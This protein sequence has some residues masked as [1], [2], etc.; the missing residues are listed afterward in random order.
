MLI[1]IEAI[2]IPFRRRYYDKGISDVKAGWD[3]ESHSWFISTRYYV[4]CSKDVSISARE[5]ML[6]EDDI[7]RVCKNVSVLDIK[8]TTISMFCLVTRDVVQKRKTD[9]FVLSIKLK[10]LHQLRKRKIG[11]LTTKSFPSKLYCCES[12]MYQ[13]ENFT[14]WR[15]D[16][17]EQET[18][19]DL[20]YSVFEKNSTF[21]F[22]IYLYAKP[23]VELLLSIQESKMFSSRSQISTDVINDTLQF[24]YSLKPEYDE[25]GRIAGL[26]IYK[27]FHLHAAHSWFS[28]NKTCTFNE[29]ILPTFQSKILL[30]KA[31]SVTYQKYRFLPKMF[32]VGIFKKVGLSEG[33]GYYIKSI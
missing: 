21:D 26:E 27:V 2:E 15:R 28:T 18:T 10:G 32:F 12:Y 30:R 3:V 13:G 4:N 25:E 6:T 7:I 8:L 33:R 19:I 11:R 23:Q 24:Q 5:L 1:R 16:C 20:N 14:S 17:A 9:R 31:V 22:E 29:L